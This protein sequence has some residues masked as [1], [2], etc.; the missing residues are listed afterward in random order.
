MKLPRSGV[1]FLGLLATLA[2]HHADAQ[3]LYQ[4]REPTVACINPRATAAL[5]SND[6]RRGDPGWINYVMQ[7]GRC[8]QITPASRWELVKPGPIMLMR[9]VVPG[10]GAEFYIASGALAALQPVRVPAPSTPYV[11]P[12]RTAT[13]GDTNGSK[14]CTDRN[15][16]MLLVRPDPNGDLQFG[17]SSW[18]SRG[19]FFGESGTALAEGSGSWVYRNA[20]NDPDPLARCEMRITRQ[21]AGYSAW[22]T[23]EGPCQA[24]QGFS[25]NPNARLVFPASSR[26]GGIPA[27]KPM[28][29]AVSMESGGESCR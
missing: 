5:T 2:S 27:S 4:A 14:Y 3:A 9:N 17:V 19:H 6:P 12:P 16:T 18:D 10:T 21:G 1:F 29:Q 7:D 11:S 8:V 22:V 24:D 23:P 28:E 15:S 20:M 13:T 25:P 26:R